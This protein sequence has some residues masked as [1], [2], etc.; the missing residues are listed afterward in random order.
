M[1][2][3][4]FFTVF[5]TKRLGQQDEISACRLF[6]SI[7]LQ[8]PGQVD[9][10]ISPAL[11]IIRVKLED[12]EEYRKPG[13]KIFLLEVIINAIYYN[14]VATLQYL[15]HHN[16]LMKFLHMWFGE[17][18]KFLRVHDKTLSILAIM[19]IVQLPPEHIPPSLQTQEALQYLMKAMLTFFKS[20]PDALARRNEALEY[21]DGDSVTAEGEGEWN[22]EDSWSETEDSADVADEAQEY[23]DF[24]A[25]QVVPCAIH[26]NADC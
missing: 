12:E 4:Y 13:Y 7:L 15:E 6:E 1:L 8:M 21:E 25:Q 3:D 20:L 11:D 18:E 9:N 2:F 26:A 10:Y 17:A 14:P 16:F 23:L 5:N 24:L 22:E 19:K